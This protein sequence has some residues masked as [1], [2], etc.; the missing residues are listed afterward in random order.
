M[1]YAL[2]KKALS[3]LI[4]GYLLSVCSPDMSAST[5]WERHVIDDSESGADGV[6]LADFNGDGLPDITTGWEESGVT[7]LYLHPGIDS[8]AK[9][10]PAVTVG[11]VTS[12]E[13]A[14]PFDFNRDGILD[15]L[16]AC[17]GRNR[18]LYVHISPT[19][20][21]DLLDPD[22]WKTQLV[23]LSKGKQMW[24]YMTGMQSRG[25]TL[26]WTGSKGA[27]GSVGTFYMDSKS[28]HFMNWNWKVMTSAGW[29]MSLQSVDMDE[30]GESEML[31]SDRRGATSGVWLF[32]REHQ[33]AEPI[34]W[35]KELI[36]CAGEEVMFLDSGDMNQ[37]GRLD[38]VV[39]V[40]PNLIVALLQPRNW[41]VDWKKIVIQTPENF[42]AA[43]A[44]AV[45]DINQDGRLDCVFSC[46]GADKGRSGVGYVTCDGW[47]TGK[48]FSFHEIANREG[49]KFD[50][51]ELVD[52]D[53]D[54]DLDVLTCE[55][56]DLLGVIWYEN[57]TQ[58]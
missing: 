10:W 28:P 2:L 37:D 54:G 8:V 29:I 25:S 57:P 21:Q 19:Q 9:P 46:E 52:L 56:R 13:D 45:G 55:E 42:G 50:R 11:R 48:G 14:Y 43:K 41:G 18:S 32:R 36:G 15:V 33:D 31:F 51:I 1:R 3:Q 20:K 53:R 49:V 12:P 39:A 26:L 7:R 5:P 34:E 47:D 38:V 40:K 6:R 44:V 16:S 17:E 27:G 58:N 4:C 35:K 24:M 30:D 23:P 22:K